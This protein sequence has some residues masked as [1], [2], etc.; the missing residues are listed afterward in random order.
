MALKNC[1]EVMLCGF[2][3][4]QEKAL[5]HGVC[6]AAIDTKFDGLNGGLNG[7]RCCWTVD[8][9]N[10]ATRLGGIAAVKNAACRKCKFYRQVKRESAAIFQDSASTLS[11]WKWKRQGTE[12]IRAQILV[13]LILVLCLLLGVSI[14]GIVYNKY[15]DL[16][17]M[18]DADLEMGKTHFAMEVNSA[19]E[20]LIFMLRMFGD[21]HELQ[22]AWHRKDR[23]TMK[24]M[25]ESALTE[26]THDKN[27]CHFTLFAPDLMYSLQLWGEHP[28]GKITA[29]S[30][31]SLLLAVENQSPCHGLEVSNGSLTLTVA[32]PWMVG[33]QLIGYIEL[34]QEISKLLPHVKETAGVMMLFVLDKAYIDR[35]QWELGLKHRGSPGNWDLLHGFVIDDNRITVV[36]D[37][38]REQ[39]SYDHLRHTHTT[40]NFDMGGKAYHSIIAPIIDSAGRDVGNMVVLTETGAALRSMYVL[41]AVLLGTGFLVGGGLVWGFYVFLG[42]LQAQVVASNDM[43]LAEV[44]ER[45]KAEEGE[46]LA[47]KQA[48]LANR[49]KSEF[50]ANMSHEIRTPM[51]GVIG[52]IG[53]VLNTDLDSRQLKFLTMA[54]GAANNTMKLINNILDLSKIEAGRLIL[55]KVEFSLDTVGQAV[56]D[57]LAS[58]ALEKEIGLRWENSDAPATL[59]GDPGCLQQIILNLAGNAVKFTTHGEVVIASSLWH[60]PLPDH[61]VAA[62]GDTPWSTI[63]EPVALHVTVRDTGIGIADDKK[64]TIFEAFRQADGSTTR[65]YGG[66]GL[67]LS[68]SAGLAT[69]MGGR[70]WVE[71]EWGKGSTFHLIVRLGRVE[72]K[73]NL[74]LESQ[75]VSQASPAPLLAGLKALVVEDEDLIRKVEASILEEAGCL[76]LTAINGKIALEILDREQVDFVIMD[77][78][79]PELDGY[80]TCRRIRAAEKGSSRHL[81]I[82]GVTAEA[83]KQDRERCLASGAD[84][85]MS[86][87]FDATSL[88]STIKNAVNKEVLR[89]KVFDAGAALR[90]AAGDPNAAAAALRKLL[91]EAPR[92]V[93]DLSAA[94]A[95][96][97]LVQL[98]KKAHMLKSLAH[99]GGASRCADLV[100]RLELRLRKGKLEKAAGNI[101][102]IST[103]LSEFSRMA[104]NFPGFAKSSC[105]SDY[106]VAP[107]ASGPGP[108]NATAGSESAGFSSQ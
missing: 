2:G 102:D 91:R 19:A 29:N 30:H 82:I 46:R 34:G 88:L 75:S 17:E 56:V 85:Y 43:I 26:M 11:S 9:T 40:A 16:H 12:R 62:A 61:A 104:A 36:P 74:A 108:R 67:G 69:L 92:L 24:R 14:G 84:I 52:M 59:L 71:S 103:A 42:K 90:N 37:A 6:P 45:Q 94:L 101:A 76:V 21:N 50:L 1:W 51:T 31:A 79:M 93:H 8:G 106:F 63:E 3:P 68:I 48:E 57:T 64:Q 15:S 65:Q 55:D 7:G 13:P 5:R 60:G 22:A 53:L 96:K 73:E 23:E 58:Q 54:K 77:M 99:R 25:A 83:F 32:Y 80:E 44:S 105:Q 81:P 27:I 20:K 78:R 98:E 10:C 4:G 38:L 28:V 72:P 18:A 66:T 41:V 107:A 100:M 33:E 87:P 89:G 35:A 70:I 49:A 39:L 97:D 95:A 86:K 47:R